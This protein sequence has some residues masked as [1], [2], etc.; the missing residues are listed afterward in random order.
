MLEGIAV[1][2]GIVVEVVG[3]AEEVVAR[4][5]HVTAAHV[6]TRKPHFLGL[7]YHHHILALA[8]ECLSDLVSEVG[9]GVLIGNDLHGVLHADGAVVGGEH[10]FVAQFGNA[11][12]ECESGRMAEPREGKA[13]I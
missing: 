6:R 12:E 11:A 9:V 7:L 2:L 4:A 3:V 5:K 13:A 8:V 10:H 1:V